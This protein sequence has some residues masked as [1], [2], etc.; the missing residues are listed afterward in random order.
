MLAEFRHKKP[1]NNRLH[2]F[3][4]DADTFLATANNYDVISF[5]SVLHHLP[6]YRATLFRCD[7][8]L[9]PGG[10]LYVTHE[11][12]L[13]AERTQPAPIQNML[14]RIGWRVWGIWRHMMRQSFPQLNYSLSDV[15][16]DTGISPDDLL[17]NLEVLGRKTIFVRRYRVE[18]LAVVAWI[19]NTL[20]GCRPQQFAFMAQKLSMNDQKTYHDQD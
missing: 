1:E 17:D 3:Q 6:D 15:H 2:L 4:T 19:N 18:P 10:V 16:V 5:S 8:L 7:E 11:P 12:L 14:T 20:F 13:K 9:V